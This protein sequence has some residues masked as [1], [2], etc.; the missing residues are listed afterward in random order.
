[1]DDPTFD[2]SNSTATV[3]RRTAAGQV[4][5]FAHEAQRGYRQFFTV[6]V[7]DH[8]VQVHVGGEVVQTYT[9]SNGYFD[10]SIVDH[11]LEPGWG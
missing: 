8:P 5:N 4:E 10:V 9:D 11:G 6:Q 2:D 3:G 1:M 7:G